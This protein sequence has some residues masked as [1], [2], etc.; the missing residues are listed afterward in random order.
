MGPSFD[1]NDAA[2]A[3]GRLDRRGAVEALNAGATFSAATSAALGFA[4]LFVIFAA[5][6]FLLDPSMLDELPEPLDRFV[7]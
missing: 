6:H 1:G 3:D 4:R 2:S 5:A 7:D